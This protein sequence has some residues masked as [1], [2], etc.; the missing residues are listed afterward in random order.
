MPRAG[1][2]ALALLLLTSVAFGRA[3]TAEFTNWDD[4]KNI[5]D[6]ALFTRPAAAG[7]DVGW[8]WRHAYMDLY[9]PVTFSIWGL[10]VPVARVDTPDVLGAALNPWVFHTVNV[11]LH[12]LATLAA[13]VLLRRLLRHVAGATEEARDWGTFLGAAV[14]ALHPVQV[15]PVAWVS[16]M[17]DVLYGLLV[18]VAL[19]QYLLWAEPEAGPVAGK[20]GA[21]R[22]HP[23]LHYALA[24]AAYV[25]A[26]LTK[27]TAIVTPILALVLVWL[28]RTRTTRAIPVEEHNASEGPPRTDSDATPP[29]DYEH[30]KRGR[31]GRPLLG[32]LPWALLAVP[33]IVVTRIVQQ[34]PYVTPTPW[35]QRPFV[36]GDALAFYLRKVAF[37]H[38]LAI[39]YG[40]TP[41]VVM[42]DARAYTAWL[43]PAGVAAA[44]ALWGP[45]RRWLGA[46]GLV[47]LAPLLPVLGLVNFDFQYY[48][49]V[50]DHYLYLPMFGVALAVGW[51]VARYA[52]RV[53]RNIGIGVVALLAILT[54]HQ[55]G[56]WG[57]PDRLLTHSID[58]APTV[59]MMYNNRGVVRMARGRAE[60]NAG[61]YAGAMDTFRTAQR[62]FKEAITRDPMNVMLQDNYVNILLEQDRADDAIRHLMP[63]LKSMPTI[64]AH[65][66]EFLAPLYARLGHLLVNHGND[67]DAVVALREALS[68]LP[69]S[70]SVRQDLS[71]AESRLAASQ[72]AATSPAAAKSTSPA[73][74]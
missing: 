2:M 33:V 55:A 42:A 40:R 26:L 46:A 21:A 43:V 35:W 51:A 27:P 57:D 36:A 9:V 64:S 56:Y 38:A 73:G 8:F 4:D 44:V 10:L 70:E 54:I 63:L 6:N 1:R 7:V 50:A 12:V 65:K 30:A 3:C 20:A 22:A 39:A 31:P 23:V 74:S 69:K 41:T 37:P 58:V 14:F 11:F 68:H 13:F 29:L 53:G 72:P 17:K 61:E 25:V 71:L 67:R 24:T 32:L 15:E 18:L 34:A 47:F 19:W 60:R 49:T 16:G 28:V 62:D 5:W 45:G 66:R 52:G 59:P 48:S